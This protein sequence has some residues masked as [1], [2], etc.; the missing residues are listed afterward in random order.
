MGVFGGGDGGGGRV[1]GDG[2]RGGW[3]V[4]WLL[5]LSLVVHDSG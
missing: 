4:T 3:G 5:M 1:D 2:G